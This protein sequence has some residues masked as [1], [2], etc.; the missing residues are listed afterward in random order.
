LTKG[1]MK[2]KI[3]FTLKDRNGVELNEGDKVN[4]ICENLSVEEC[5]FGNIVDKMWNSGEVIHGRLVFN[6]T[7]EYVD[8][9]YTN[10]PYY[11]KYINNPRESYRVKYM[12]SNISNLELMFLSNEGDIKWSIECP[13]VENDY[14]HEKLEKV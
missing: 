7:K 9:E 5:T 13:S 1:G 14:R 10:R 12:P 3:E 11:K 2:L 8:K 4:W 6:H